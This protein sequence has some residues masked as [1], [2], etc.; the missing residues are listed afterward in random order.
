LVWA[1][2]RIVYVFCSRYD[3]HEEE[4]MRERP[5]PPHLYNA[6]I[7]SFRVRC[8][9]EFL[10]VESQPLSTYAAVFDAYGG[11]RASF[12]HGMDVICAYLNRGCM[13]PPNLKLTV[14]NAAME[15]WRDVVLRRYL[16]QI[17]ARG[18]QE[19]HASPDDD[20]AVLLK[21]AKKMFFDR[22]Q[23]HEITP[24]L[25]D[26][27][28]L[29]ELQQRLLAEPVRH[30]PCVPQ[31]GWTRENHHLSIVATREAVHTLLLVRQ[32]FKAN[33]KAASVTSLPQ[34]CILDTWSLIASFLP[35]RYN[36]TAQ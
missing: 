26:F 13:S 32:R 25:I 35:C 29:E 34:D 28:T 33:P 21:S 14:Y 31:S 6:V 3:I 18:A 19:G 4:R 17:L 22:S 36:Y 30:E 27:S 20:I 8:S 9:E 1:I 10:A 24:L 15:V 16:T 12:G 7:D 5:S 23:P 11:C 2:Y